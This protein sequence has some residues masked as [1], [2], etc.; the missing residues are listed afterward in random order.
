MFNKI[1]INHS[2]SCNKIRA[3]WYDICMCVYMCVYMYSSVYMCI[4]IHR[5]VYIHMY[6]YIYMNYVCKYNILEY[7]NCSTLNHFIFII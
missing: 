5:S 6:M 4:C 7:L 3:C 1:K 2:D